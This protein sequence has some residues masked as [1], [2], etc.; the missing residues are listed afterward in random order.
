MNCGFLYFFFYDFCFYRDYYYAVMRW[1]TGNELFIQWMN[2]AQNE[3][4]CMTY[5]TNDSNGRVVSNFL[6]FLL[7][8]PKLLVL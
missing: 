4:V 7:V 2:R 3:T 6:S 8:P 1:T 5:K